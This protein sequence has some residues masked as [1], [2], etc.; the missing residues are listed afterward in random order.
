MEHSCSL[1][2]SSSLEHSC[3]LDQPC[4]YI[5]TIMFINQVFDLST[6]ELLFVSW[7][8]PGCRWSEWHL[9]GGCVWSPVSMEIEWGASCSSSLTI[10]VCNNLLL[11]WMEIILLISCLFGGRSFLLFILFSSY[12]QHSTI[13]LFI[14]FY[15]C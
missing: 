3:A 4:F 12:K 13:Y 8:D 2:H 5:Q 1:E 15:L 11:L 14:E 6:I 10:F 9:Y 7:E